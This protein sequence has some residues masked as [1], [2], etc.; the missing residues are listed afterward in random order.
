MSWTTRHGP[1]TPG[2]PTALPPGRLPGCPAAGQWRALQERRKPAD[3]ERAAAKARFTSGALAAGV[4]LSHHRSG[5]FADLGSPVTGL[6]ENP[7]V[8]EPWQPVDP[9]DY[10]PAG[11]QI[12]AVVPAPPTC[13]ARS[14]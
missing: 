4:V 8:K 13:S 1:D 14:T 11:Q 12:T 10:P 7:R 5:F 3:E 6:V 2:H 9:R